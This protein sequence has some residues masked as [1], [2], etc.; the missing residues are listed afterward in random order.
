MWDAVMMDRAAISNPGKLPSLGVLK[1]RDLPRDDWN[2]DT[3]YILGRNKQAA[4]GLAEI[5]NMEDWGGMVSVHDDP[6]DVEGVPETY[7]IDRSGELV[8]VH[9]PATGASAA[10][11]DNPMVW[12]SEAMMELLSALLDD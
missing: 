6:E 12:E 9:D 7:I 4:Y 1:L 11:I 3:L 2:V 10:K 5:F 8:A